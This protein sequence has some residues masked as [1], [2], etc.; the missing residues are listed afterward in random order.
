MGGLGVQ[1]A[2]TSNKVKIFLDLF[3]WV[4]PSLRKLAP[5]QWPGEQWGWR[6]GQREPR[7]SVQAAEVMWSLSLPFSLLERQLQSLFYCVV[8]GV[9]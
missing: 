4:G 1:E 6:G 9:E 2:W 7:P 5:P 8:V 3:K